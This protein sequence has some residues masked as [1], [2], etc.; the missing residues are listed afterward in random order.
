LTAV[1]PLDHH[2]SMRLKVVHLIP[3]RP[4]VVLAAVASVAT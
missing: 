1:P 4:E 3:P 2:P